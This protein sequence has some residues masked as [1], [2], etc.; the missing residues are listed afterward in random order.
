MEANRESVK[1]TE[2]C[3]RIKNNDILVDVSMELRPGKIYGL[4]GRNGSGKTMLFRAM[5][6]LI[7]IDSGSVV[8]FGERIGVDVSFPSSL[9]ITIEN[10]GLWK[11][12]TGFENLKLLADIKKI[13]GNEEI[14]AAMQRVGLDPGDR[15]R[16][17]AYSLGMR[18]KLAI[19]QAIMERP[20]LLILDEPTNS[21]D[22]SSVETIHGVLREERE[23]GAVCI[24][25]SHQKEDLRRLCDEIFLMDAGKCRKLEEGQ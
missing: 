15:R 18:Q 13:I 14:A 9:G 21:L 25:A 12:L 19:A 11:Q 1:L 7:A 2:V 24:L 5:A 22:E 17:G 10:V 20:R 8:A 23:R 3:K 6:G 16:Y 4:F